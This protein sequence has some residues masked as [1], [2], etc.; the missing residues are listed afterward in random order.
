MAERDLVEL[1][2]RAKARPGGLVGLVQSACLAA[3]LAAFLAANLMLRL[4]FCRARRLRPRDVAFANSSDRD[5]SKARA[6]TNQGG[7]Y[8]WFSLVFFI[9]HNI[10]YATE[11]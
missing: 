2:S 6:T 4:V 1:R 9:F 11:I 3:F 10:P 5:R 7:L 8:Q